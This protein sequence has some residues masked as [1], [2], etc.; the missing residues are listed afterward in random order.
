MGDINHPVAQAAI[1]KYRENAE[2]DYCSE[3]YDAEVV[4][5]CFGFE[6]INKGIAWSGFWSQGDG[7]SIEVDWNLEDAKNVIECVKANFPQDKE[8][9]KMVEGF[10]SELNNLTI[11]YVAIRRMYH[12]RYAHS[13]T[14]GVADY[15]IKEE[16]DGHDDEAKKDTEY[17]LEIIRS[18]S[19]WLY[20]RLEESYEYQSSDEVIMQMFIDNGYEFDEDGNII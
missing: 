6:V 19:D 10:V 3:E 20:K 16:F 18:I 13:N 9:N 15:Q 12:T 14:L 17:I 2:Y 5:K 11:D 7:A 8:L 1:E 4:A